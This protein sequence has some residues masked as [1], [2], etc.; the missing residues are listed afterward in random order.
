MVGIVERKCVGVKIPEELMKEFGKYSEEG[1]RKEEEWMRK[2]EEWLEYKKENGPE[3]EY[4]W[5]RWRSM[6]NAVKN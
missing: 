3:L 1:M 4:Q 2:M 6:G 5:N